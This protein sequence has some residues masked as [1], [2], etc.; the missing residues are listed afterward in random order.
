MTGHAH[1]SDITDTCAFDLVKTVDDR[2]KYENGSLQSCPKQLRNSLKCS[3]T[4][5]KQL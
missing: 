4:A 2:V 1:F 5:Q 3:I